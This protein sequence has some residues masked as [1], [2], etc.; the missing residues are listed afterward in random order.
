MMSALPGFKNRMD[1]LTC[2]LHHL[3]IM[4]S[5]DS[6]LS[7]TPTNLLLVT[8]VYPFPIIFQAEV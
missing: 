7:A 4:D 1:P 2:V 3:S 5:S 6:P 8:M